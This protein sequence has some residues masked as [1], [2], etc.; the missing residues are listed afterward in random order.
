LAISVFLVRRKIV[1]MR[2]KKTTTWGGNMYPK[3]KQH[4]TIEKSAVGAPYAFR[5]EAAS[6]FALDLPRPQ[7]SYNNPAPTSHNNPASYAKSDTP[8]IS[9]KPDRASVGRTA[10]VRCTF[11]PSLPDELSISNGEI[12]R[13]VSEYD[14]GWA[15]CANTRDEQGMVPL[16]CLQKATTVVPESTGG[17]DWRNAQR[18]SSLASPGSRRY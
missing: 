2:N 8:T 6:S 10:T 9:T 15:L 1:G 3:F 16:E 17:V 5:H 4:T 11:I 14:D 7:T 18:A 13:I 12:V